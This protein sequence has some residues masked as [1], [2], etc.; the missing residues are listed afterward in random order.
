MLHLNLI[1]RTNGVGLDRDVDLI[2]QVA[3]AAGHKVTISHCREIS[4]FSQWLGR[5]NIF[6]T[7]IFLE[8]IFPRWLGSAKT[9]I[10][11]P[12]QERFPHRHLPRLKKIDHVFCKSKHALAVFSQHHPSCLYTGF[13]SANLDQPAVPRRSRGILHLAGRSTLKGTATVLALWK[14]RPDWP[15]LT[16]LQ[17]KD[18]AP[19]EVPQ[20]VKLITNYLS[21]EDIVTLINEH[22]I[23]LCPSLSEGWGHYIVEAMSCGATVITTDGPPMNDLIQPDRGILVNAPE[24]E[25]RHLGTNFKVAPDALESAINQALSLSDK[26]RTS[27]A[28]H[29]RSWTRENHRQFAERFT[30]ALSKL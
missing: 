16:L 2:H 4:L 3:T 14:K 29:A 12:N 8:R 5:K 22:P 19:E 28:D 10:L 20:N 1:A 23:H 7:N 15:V 17:H 30:K 18:N 24:N 9:N 27:I 13:T 6:D 11:I 21:Q 25:P 26:N